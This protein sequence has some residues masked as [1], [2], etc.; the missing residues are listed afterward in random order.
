[1]KNKR[2]L[3]Q[4]L[5]GMFILAALQ[6][7]A[8]TEDKAA[9][10]DQLI[11]ACHG[12]GIINGAILVAEKGRVIY[13]KAIGTANVE[14]D[15]PNSPDT[16]FSL[17]SIS[18]QFTAMLA[19]MMVEE[20]KLRLDGKILDHLPYFREDTGGRITVH[21][22]L[23]HTHG[24]P[25]VCYNKLPYRNKLSKEAFF[26]EYYSGDLE[27]EPGSGFAYGDG[28]DIL[29]AIVE[30]VS[31]R[32]FEALM[33]ERI[34]DPL[35]M[36]DSGFLHARRNTRKHAS[37]YADSL[38]VKGEP[39]YELPLNGSSALFSTVDDLFRW[40]RALA[41]NKLLAKRFQD[42]MFSVQADFGRPYG[43]AFDIA[44]LDFGGRKRK[45][46][47]H[48]GSGS[49][50]IF[51]SLED[52]HLVI[53]LNNILGENVLV[54]REIMNILYGLPFQAVRHSAQ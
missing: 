52:G 24:I 4:I 16:R 39:L 22:I 26:R 15:I 2:I 29:A 3:S 1:L 17:F 8:F 31:G 43:Y 30:V 28:F 19:M 41:E 6:S 44:K 53:L 18:K 36:K 12:N 9:K 32:P 45:V 14:W 50:I 42:M 20:G 21:Q 13:R 38:A 5:L 7:W 33:Q 40:D 49:A 47:W 27:F 34:F 25:Y 51:R 48:E 54:S 23:C 37:D 35:G 11:K 46:V 10:I